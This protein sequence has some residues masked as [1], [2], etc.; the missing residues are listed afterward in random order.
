[1]IQEWKLV[2]GSIRK[3]QK[4][5]KMVAVLR[6]Y[7]GERLIEE[8]AS[9]QLALEAPLHLDISQRVEGARGRA[10][11]L[12]TWF[13]AFQLRHLQDL[14]AGTPTH[15]QVNAAD[16]FQAVIPWEQLKEAAIKYAEEEGP[17]GT[18]PAD[19]RANATIGEPS[20]HIPIADTPLRLYVPHG[21]SECLNVKRVIRITFLYEPER[22]ESATYGF[23]NVVSVQDLGSAGK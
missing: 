20:A 6:I 11:D 17:A 15:L 18:A 8:V 1:M 22:D 7:A 9:A 4:E 14:P 19:S 21:S 23:R 10:F 12:L 13:A 2:R 5:G 16:E 3:T